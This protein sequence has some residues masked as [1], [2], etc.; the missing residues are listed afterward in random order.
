MFSAFTAAAYNSSDSA[1]RAWGNAISTALAAVGL[2][3]LD[4]D[5]NWSTVSRPGTAN[6][7]A[8]YEVWRLTA[9]L[10]GASPVYIRLRYGSGS[11]PSTSVPQLWVATATGYGGSGST[12][13]G[14]TSPEIPLFRV[15][16]AGVDTTPRHYLAS[17][18]GHGFTLACYDSPQQ[19]FALVVDRQRRSDGAAQPNPG[20]PDIG[21]GRLYAGRDGGGS[22]I[23]AVCI[24]DPV[25]NE[26]VTL[27]R[28]P[29]LV[30][31]GLTSLT[32]MIDVDGN[33]LNYVTWL[34]SRQGLYTTKMI[35]GFG[36]FDV[37][38]P[39]NII[40]VDHLGSTDD[41]IF[42]PSG[43][44]PQVDYLGTNGSNLALWWD[45]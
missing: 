11:S 10:T 43:T 22:T 42:L 26:A 39:L 41:F 14:T 28:W 40:P 30:R 23:K 32:P 8:G 34:P 19:V 29:S 38:T 12:L 44:C 27:T 21:H 15:S 20:D 31:V 2:T 3:K 18:D 37:T 4:T 5:I 24:V 36:V 9:P 7:A 6:T 45:T 1:F 25:A 35:V 16:G 13:S 17:S 33:M